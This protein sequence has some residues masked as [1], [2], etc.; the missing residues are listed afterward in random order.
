MREGKNDDEK[1]Q[2]ERQKR[3]LKRGK[4]AGKI[5][6]AGKENRCAAM[7]IKLLILQPVDACQVRKNCDY[8]QYRVVYTYFLKSFRFWKTILDFKT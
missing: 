5:L 4:K 1:N 2:I 3:D 6:S 7:R 8:V